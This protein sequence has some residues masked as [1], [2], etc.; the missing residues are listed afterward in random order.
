MPSAHA[1]ALARILEDCDALRFVGA[2]SG[3]DP[4]ELAE[5][6]AKN[7]AEM[8]SEKLSAPS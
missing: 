6:A 1:E 8:R 2:G 3:V 5:R 4:L 7:A